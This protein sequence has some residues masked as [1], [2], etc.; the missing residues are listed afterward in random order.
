MSRFQFS[1]SST[2]KLRD[3]HP[4][5]VRVVCLALKL[6]KVDFKVIEGVRTKER[7][8]KLYVQGRTEPGQ[9]VTWTKNSNHFKD[10]ATGYGYAVDLLPAPYDWKDL[11][12]FDLMAEAMFE[13]ARQLNVKIRWGADWNQN[14]KAREKGE[15]DS[16]H[17]E[18]VRI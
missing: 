9:I 17:F 18:L 2:E 14:G 3:I 15:S 12:K 8:L 7:Q 11:A 5:L 6:S 13:A 10:E 1:Q 4:D 16:P